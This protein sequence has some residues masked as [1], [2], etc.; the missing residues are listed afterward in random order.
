M[1]RV[2]YWTDSENVYYWV[3]NQSREFIPF[4][5]NRIGEIQRTTIPEQ[6]PGTE[7]PADLPTRRFIGGRP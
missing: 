6:V 7:N 2:I 3:R 5:A 4:V 1:D